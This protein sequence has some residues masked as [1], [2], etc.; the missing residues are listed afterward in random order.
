ML[1]PR[2]AVAE[3]IR[4]GLDGSTTIYGRP[5]GEIVM[6]IASEPQLAGLDASWESV[7]LSRF[8]LRQ[9]FDAQL[10]SAGTAVCAGRGAIES[11][12]S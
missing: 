9:P 4:D 6:D 11:H 10:H 5:E 1:E 7:E 2:I 12:L 8:L 3:G